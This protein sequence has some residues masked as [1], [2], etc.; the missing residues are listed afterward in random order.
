MYPLPHR[1]YNYTCFKKR[2][3]NKNNVEINM[4]TE[5]EIAVGMGES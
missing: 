5:M 1:K 2:N 3:D 4:K